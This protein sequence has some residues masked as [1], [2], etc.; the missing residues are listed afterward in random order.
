MLNILPCREKVLYLPMLRGGWHTLGLLFEGG[1]KF[2]FAVCCPNVSLL[3]VFTAYDGVLRGVSWNCAAGASDA[4]VRGFFLFSLYVF[5][6]LPFGIAWYMASP[7]TGVNITSFFGLRKFLTFFRVFFVFGDIYIMY[8]P[9][10][11]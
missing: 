7:L 1:W 4:V 6:V 10:A 9:K 3:R 11:V 2:V 5:P 8:K